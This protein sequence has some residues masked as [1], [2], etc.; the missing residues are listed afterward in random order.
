MEGEVGGGGVVDGDVAADE[1][2]GDGIA[3]LELKVL[4]SGELEFHHVLP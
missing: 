1:E 2:V 4:V 3:G